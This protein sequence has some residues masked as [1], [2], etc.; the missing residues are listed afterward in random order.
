MANIGYSIVSLRLN[1][2]AAQDGKTWLLL[3]HGFRSQEQGGEYPLPTDR[4][5]LQRLATI[6]IPPNKKDSGC[7]YLK[8]AV[9]ASKEKQRRHISAVNDM[10]KR[11]ETIKSRQY[12]YTQYIKD[13]R[14]EVRE[15]VETVQKE[16]EQAIASLTDLFSLGRK[17]LD[18]Q[19]RAHIENK[20]WQGELI[21]ARAF[22]ECFR[23]VTQAVKGLGLPSKERSQATD[24]IIE[25]VAAALKDTQETVALA[26]SAN[27]D[28][29][30][31]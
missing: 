10:H 23:M 1:L 11:E 6:Y 24:V 28:E 31:H 29:V 12:D 16:A 17:G 25:E 26:F 20:E 2:K 22:R 5:D 30:K 3:P 8:R 4:Q 19:M 14:R 18:G 15:A 7:V 27:D 13:K 21:D 9:A